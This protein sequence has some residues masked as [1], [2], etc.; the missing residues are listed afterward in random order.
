MPLKLAAE[1]ESYLSKYLYYLHANLLPCLLAYRWRVNT[2]M[3]L[4]L[5]SMPAISL[6]LEK[7]FCGPQFSH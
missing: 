5:D 4:D 1:G 6:A 3:Q 7:G 2:E